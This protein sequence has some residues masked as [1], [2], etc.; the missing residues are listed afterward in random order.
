M[1]IIHFPDKDTEALVS[2]GT[3]AKSQSKLAGGKDAW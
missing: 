3:H 2:Y 1:E